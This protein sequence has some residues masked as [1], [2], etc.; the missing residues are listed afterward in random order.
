MVVPDLPY[1][2]ECTKTETSLGNPALAA[3]IEASAEAKRM[4]LG[5]QRHNRTSGS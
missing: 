1:L 2:K 4:E 5:G 3:E